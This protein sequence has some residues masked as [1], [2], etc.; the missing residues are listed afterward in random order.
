MSRARRR[1]Q[2]VAMA[3]YHNRACDLSA[4]AF[5]WA[6]SDAMTGRESA[7]YFFVYFF[8][9]NQQRYRRSRAPRRG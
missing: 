8:V 5:S 4:Y 7:S 1:R 9:R 3:R 2:V 6:M